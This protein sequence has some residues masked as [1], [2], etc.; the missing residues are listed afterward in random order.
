[1]GWI[2]GKI[3]IKTKYYFILNLINGTINLPHKAIRVIIHGERGVNKKGGV[4]VT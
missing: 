1:M 3:S 2:N 4:L